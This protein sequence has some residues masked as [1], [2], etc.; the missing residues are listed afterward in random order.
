MDCSSATLAGGNV[1]QIARI[2]QNFLRCYACRGA[3]AFFIRLLAVLAKSINL[4]NFFSCGILFRVRGQIC[5][6]S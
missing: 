6:K 4:V 2:S 5:V 3:D 1:T